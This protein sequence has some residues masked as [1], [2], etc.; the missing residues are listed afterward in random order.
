MHIIIVILIIIHKI[1]LLVIFSCCVRMCM[2]EM[3]L[4]I[5]RFRILNWTLDYHLFYNLYCICFFHTFIKKAKW[6]KKIPP[7]AIFPHHLQSGFGLRDGTART[8]RHLFNCRPL[9]SPAT[10]KPFV[11]GAPLSYNR[12][13]LVSPLEEKKKAFEKE[14]AIR[15]EIE[16]NRRQEEEIHW[17]MLHWWGVLSLITDKTGIHLWNQTRKSPKVQVITCFKYRPG[18]TWRNLLYPPFAL[19]LC[20]NI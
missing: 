2:C 6:K 7:E 16:K 14:W 3:L 9:P 20:P 13:Y 8:E 11:T 19:H 17:P 10:I 5:W 4:P 1:F 12:A 18:K 15:R